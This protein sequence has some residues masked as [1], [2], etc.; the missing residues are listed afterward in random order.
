VRWTV[1][2]TVVEATPSASPSSSS[3]AS[4]PTSIAE[5]S[6]IV[7]PP[8]IVHLIRSKPTSGQT[9][10][11]SGT[12]YTTIGSSKSPAILHLVER[13]FAL[14]PTTLLLTHGRQLSLPVLVALIFH[15]TTLLFGTTALLFLQGT[16][17][18][19]LLHTFS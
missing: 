5:V 1:P 17:F 6:S 15:P 19:S 9:G 18:P 11:T 8:P 4:S 14:I 16:S 12:S 3:P 13:T 2:V 10:C 7:K